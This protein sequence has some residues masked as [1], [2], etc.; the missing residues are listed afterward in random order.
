MPGIP[1]THGFKTFVL[2]V[3]VS[4][5]RLWQLVGSQLNPKGYTYLMIAEVTMYLKADQLH[6]LAPC[7]SY[8]LHLSGGWKGPLSLLSDSQKQ[9]RYQ[10]DELQH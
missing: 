9:T 2:L 10:L 8:G 6:P 7:K 1:S 3:D 4:S 5:E